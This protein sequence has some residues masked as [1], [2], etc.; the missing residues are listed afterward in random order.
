MTDDT[1]RLLACWS[2]DP[3]DHF[4]ATRARLIPLNANFSVFLEQGKDHHV[5]SLTLKG[6]TYS[7]RE[8][9]SHDATIN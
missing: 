8:K 5:Q 4:D 1:R 9:K 3:P 7:Q 6:M 2:R